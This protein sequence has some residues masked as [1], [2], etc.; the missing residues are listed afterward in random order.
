MLNYY[1][2]KK[3]NPGWTQ[4]LKAYLVSQLFSAC[5]LVKCLF[6]LLVY[7]MMWYAQPQ[8]FHPEVIYRFPVETENLIPKVEKIFENL[9]T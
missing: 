2:S 1:R 9:V 6:I 5:H 3:K 8:K 4:Q 7:Y